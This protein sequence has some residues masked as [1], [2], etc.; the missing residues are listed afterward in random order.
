MIL[1]KDRH[2]CIERAIYVRDRGNMILIKDRH[3][4]PCFSIPPGLPS[5]GKYDPYEG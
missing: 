5:H 4:L 2:S 1:I 3:T